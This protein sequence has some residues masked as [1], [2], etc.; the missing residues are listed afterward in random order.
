[1]WYE[2]SEGKLVWL[3]FRSNNFANFRLVNFK[4]FLLVVVIIGSIIRNYFL[5]IIVMVKFNEFLINDGYGFVLMFQNISFE[6][7]KWIL[8]GLVVLGKI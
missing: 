1:M 2:Y 5:V 7:F 3:N 6:R 8:S 4:L